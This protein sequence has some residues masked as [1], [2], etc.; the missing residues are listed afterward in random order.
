MTIAVSGE[1]AMRGR[2]L[3][4]Q[5]KTGGV[6]RVLK[7][8]FDTNVVAAPLDAS[9]GGV[10]VGANCIPSAL[11]DL[12]YVCTNVAPTIKIEVQLKSSRLSAMLDVAAIVSNSGTADCAMASKTIPIVG[13]SDECQIV[14]NGVRCWN[15]ITQCFHNSVE[16]CE[17]SE[18]NERKRGLVERFALPMTFAVSYR[19]VKAH[20]SALRNSHESRCGP[21]YT[22]LVDGQQ[23]FLST[24]ERFLS[25]GTLLFSGNATVVPFQMSTYEFR[26]SPTDCSHSK[27]LVWGERPRVSSVPVGVEVGLSEEFDA[28]KFANVEF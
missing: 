19:R 12:G 22:F 8:Q 10:V 25:Q 2:P 16:E 20:A 3:H 23:Q 17:S 6:G 11:S 21:R 1:V 26:V 4:F 14:A 9:S 5:I 28:K 18:A 7:I 15:P 13:G 27:L 24:D